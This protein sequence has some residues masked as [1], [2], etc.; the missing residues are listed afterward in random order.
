MT[1]AIIFLLSRLAAAAP[2][3]KIPEL[4]WATGHVVAI[5]EMRADPST[6]LFEAATASRYGHMGVVADTPEGLMVYHSMPPGVQKTPL[7]D[8]LGRARTDEGPE[9]GF[10]L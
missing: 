10:T 2:V 4:P 3:T 1:L 6:L 8:F 5:S 9:P 7:A